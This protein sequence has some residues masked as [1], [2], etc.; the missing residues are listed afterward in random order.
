MFFWDRLNEGVDIFVAMRFTRYDFRSIGVSSRNGTSLIFLK[1]RSRDTDAK[2]VC[3][4]PMTG[5]FVLPLTD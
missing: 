4:R 1:R 2:S 3:G 5:G